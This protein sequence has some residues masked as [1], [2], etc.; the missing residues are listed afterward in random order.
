VESNIGLITVTP[1]VAHSVQDLQQWY[2]SNGYAALGRGGDEHMSSGQWLEIAVASGQ[3]LNS[4]I[5]LAKTWAELRQTR[6]TISTATGR[7]AVVTRDSDVDLIAD[8]LNSQD[9]QP[10]ID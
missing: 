8:D 5:L 6:V 1:E 10:G 7:R 9:P 4:V 2:V 3:I